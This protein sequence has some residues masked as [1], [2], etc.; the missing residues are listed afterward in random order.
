MP[1][2]IQFGWKSKGKLWPRS[3]S[4]RFERKWKSIFLGAYS[5]ILIG[6][7]KGWRELLPCYYLVIT[8]LLSWYHH[9]ITMLLPCGTEVFKETPQLSLRETYSYHM[10]SDC[11]SGIYLG[12]YENKNWIIIKDFQKKSTSSDQLPTSSHALNK[13]LTP[14]T[15]EK[16]YLTSIAH[17]IKN[18]LRRTSEW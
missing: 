2:V 16:I 18:P 12:W 6:S 10:M 7:P 9:V 5:S 4:I 14:I 1:N 13:T 11:V 17:R 8:I 3:D 15:S